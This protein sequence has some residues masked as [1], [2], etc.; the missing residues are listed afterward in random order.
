M[1]SE[2]SQQS[3]FNLTQFA[4]DSHA[5]TSARQVEAKASRK[6]PDQVFFTNSCESYAW[7]DQSTSS[8]KTWQRSLITDWTSYSGSFPKQG[9][10]QNGQLFL[11]VHWEPVIEGVVG[12]SLPTPTASDVEG[13]IAKDT[14][15][16]NGSFYRENKKGERHGVKLKD[17][18][19]ILPTPRARDWKG[20]QGDYKAKGYGPTLPDIIKQLPTPSANEHK[21]SMSKED[22]Q[23]GTC[24]A[25]MARKDRLSAP[26]GKPMSLN[27]A[28]V[29]EMM[30][31]P[32]GHSDLKH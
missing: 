21:Y 19:S 1:T 10:M 28:F 26:T 6:K 16:K 13:G 7:Y 30:G 9:T 27:P 4:E 31:Y 3:L 24:L 12:G 32:I 17:A 8:W 15:Y 29:E 2:H 11:Q 14:Q 20:G 18:I 22:H 5:R 23:S 25:A